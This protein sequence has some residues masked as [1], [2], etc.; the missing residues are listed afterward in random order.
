M[1]Q[2]D[3]V[4]VFIG[5][6]QPFHRAH[7]AVVRDALAQYSLVCLVIGSA[8]ESGTLQNPWPAL[9][10]EIMLRSCF[11][12]SEL[13]RLAIER[14]IDCPGS[15]EE[16][17]AQVMSRVDPFVPKPSGAEEEKIVLTG[18]RK[19]AS[20]YYLDLFPEWKF[21]PHEPGALGVISATD[22]RYN[23]FRGEPEKVWAKNLHP[24]VAEW[25]KRWRVVSHDVFNKL[26]DEVLREDSSR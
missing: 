17:A 3:T 26:Q 8:Q 22:I 23:F 4:C 18:Y 21:I 20:S 9:F 25:M 6:F 24:N 19:D 12:E 1:E 5:R 11:S 13:E 10:R 2:E 15:N 14:A 16:W 7:E